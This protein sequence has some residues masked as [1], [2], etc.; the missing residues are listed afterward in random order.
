MPETAA[1][2]AAQKP[3]AFEVSSPTSRPPSC[4]LLRKVPCLI[5][6]LLLG[7][8]GFLLYLA[9]RS[10]TLASRPAASEA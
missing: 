9:V 3:R 10:V 4:Q 7:P 1:P 2:T 5:L 8:M 6:T